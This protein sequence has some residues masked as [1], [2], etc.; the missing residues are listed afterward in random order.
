MKNNNNSISRNNKN[1]N[2]PQSGLFWT[3]FFHLKKR[4]GFCFVL[5]SSFAAAKNFNFISFLLSFFA[6]LWTVKACLWDRLCD[7]DCSKFVRI[8]E[9]EQF[10]C[11]SSSGFET[12][13][14]RKVSSYSKFILVPWV[15]EYSVSSKR[16]WRNLC[17]R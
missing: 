8:Q 4:L 5:D 11:L 12:K 9:Q 6:W 17:G 10:C 2:V 16:L 14:F 7:V 3:F 1:S 15:M 13:L